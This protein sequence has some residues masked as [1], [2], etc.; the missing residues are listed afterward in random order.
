MPDRLCSGGTFANGVYTAKEAG[1]FILSATQRIDGA[2]GPW[3]RL[4]INVNNADVNA[5]LHSITG[6]ALGRR[7][8]LWSISERLRLCYGGSLRAVWPAQLMLTMLTMLT[9]V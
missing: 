8:L 6:K 5:G 2:V 3:L 9:M 4:T 1:V 7:G